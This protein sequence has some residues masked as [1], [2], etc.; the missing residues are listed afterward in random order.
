MQS[1][2][3]RAATNGPNRQMNTKQAMS[4]TQRGTSAN[5]PVDSEQNQET[6]K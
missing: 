6:A 5:Y 4:D 1:R 3:A 2:E